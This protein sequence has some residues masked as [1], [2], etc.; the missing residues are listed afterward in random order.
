LRIRLTGASTFDVAL[1]IC[2][3]DQGGCR[4]RS[5]EP[6]PTFS[7]VCSLL[8]PRAGCPDG[9]QSSHNVSNAANSMVKIAMIVAVS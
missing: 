7:R 6:H 4:R 9:P 1:E 8:A 2:I 3:N 5:Y